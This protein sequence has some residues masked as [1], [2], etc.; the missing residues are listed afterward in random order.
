VRKLTENLARV[1]LVTGATGF[2]GQHLC[3]YLRQKGYVVR[4]ATRSNDKIHNRNPSIGWVVISDIGP[5][6]DWTEALD[7]VDYVVHLAALA[8]Q[9]GTEGLGRLDEFMRTNALGTQR[10]AEAIA[11]TAHI[12]RLLFVSSIGVVTSMSKE[13][14]TDETA[15]QPD[16]DYGHSKL[17]AEIAL[18][19]TLRKT[20]SDW[21]IIRP[22]LV[23]GPGNPGNMDRLFKLVNA[24]LPLPFANINNR[25]SFV[26]VGN[27]VD[28]IE[29]C[30]TSDNASRRTFFIKDGED[31]STPELICRI[32]RQVG[33]KPRLMPMP[34]FFLRLLGKLGDTFQKLTSRSVG[35]DTYSIERLL[36]S[37]VVDDSS[38]SEELGWQ[39]PFTLDDGL[40][41]TLRE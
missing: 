9:T 18:K 17:A 5:E 23:Y 28:A 36:G 6:T 1:V 35:I 27:L 33:Q 39:P 26:Y 25:R 2:I 34:E 21:C 22:V 8:H 29:K 19:T 15:C 20:R 41:M 11:E 13:I 38:L 7:G 32:A 16:T 14:V 10:L 12:D 40:S 37:L 3:E 30:L 4:G 24:G 31:L